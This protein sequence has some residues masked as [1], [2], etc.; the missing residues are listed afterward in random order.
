MTRMRLQRALARA[1]VTSRRK[2]ETLI[3]AGRV[4]VDGALATIGMQVDVHQ[5]VTLDGRS[6]EAAGP[7]VW[8]ALNK[9]P[10]YVVTRRDQAGR[11]T[12]FDLVPAVPGLTYV[13]RLDLM[14]S[15]LLLLTT[16]GGMAHRLT[17]PRFAVPRTYRLRARGLEASV[18]RAALARPLPIDGRPVA[19]T[20]SRVRE[21]RGGLE[22]DLTLVEGRNRVVRRL[23]DV[24]GLEVD[25]LHRTRYGP[26]ELGRL[27]EGAH[28]PLTPREIDALSRL[29]SAGPLRG[30]S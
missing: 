20:E 7:A 6:V 4:R 18:L 12:V 29:E 8:L 25:A 21:V 2:A 24:V 17:H 23:A 14:T 5:R 22:V 1:G 16:D 11:P 9:P 26:V 3:R 10:G 28:R 13:G 15:G 27:A 30:R 19:I